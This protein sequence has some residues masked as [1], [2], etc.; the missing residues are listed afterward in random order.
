MFSMKG[1]AGAALAVAMFVGAPQAQA[2]FIT[3]TIEMAG[4]VGT[5]DGLGNVVGTG[6]AT[7]L[8]FTPTG[9]GGSF[10][11]LDATGD[12]SSIVSPS[13]S[14]TD[15]SFNPFAGPIADFWTIDGFSFTLE[16][17]TI[18]E[19]NASGLLLTGSGT[20]SGNGYDDTLGYWS[21]ST[22]SAGGARVAWSASASNVPAPAALGLLGLGLIGLGAAARRRKVA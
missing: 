2:A 3:G 1:L 18:V 22:Q 16:S 11:V 6:V 13:G 4:L 12:F 7:F 19:Q 5:Q 21:F 20:M 9:P 10:V 8:D 15:F 17:L 14:I